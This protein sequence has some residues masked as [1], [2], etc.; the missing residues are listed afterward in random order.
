M[1]SVSAKN[2][3]FGQCRQG[4]LKKY[5]AKVCCEN[6]ANFNILEK[7]NASTEENDILY[8]CPNTQLLGFIMGA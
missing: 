8:E 3:L 2:G 7:T 4:I 6:H 5:L 1:G